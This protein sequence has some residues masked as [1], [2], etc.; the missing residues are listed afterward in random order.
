MVA[1]AAINRAASVAFALD[2]CTPGKPVMIVL[3]QGEAREFGRPSLHGLAE[4]RPDTPLLLVMPGKTIDALW[5]MEQAL[6]S[7]S[8]GGVLGI[9]EGVELTS[10]RRL[11]FAARDGATPGFLLR[12]RGGGLSA[13]RRR[14][15][16]GAVPSAP[17]PFDAEA[18]G[19]MRLAVELVRQRDGPPG[20]WVLEHD[21]AAGGFLVV[22][23]LAAERLDAAERRAA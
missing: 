10:T 21:A 16:V 6:K 13:A 7:G 2:R 5:T 11:D 14:W 18:P 23:G 3:P 20:T 17:D 1:T 15:R 12:A 19:A 4:L 9:V 22:P 8:L